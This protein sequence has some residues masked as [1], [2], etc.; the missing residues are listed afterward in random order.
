MGTQ[1]CKQ[2]ATCQ[3]VRDP[4]DINL[5][6]PGAGHLSQILPASSSLSQSLYTSSGSLTFLVVGISSSQLRLLAQRHWGEDGHGSPDGLG[7]ATQGLE[8][9]LPLG[10]GG[11]WHAPC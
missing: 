7:D 3:V 11:G 8:P 1:R 4:V 6:D 10:W 2:E 5:F 9:C